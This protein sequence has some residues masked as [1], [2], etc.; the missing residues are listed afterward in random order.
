MHTMS[1][2]QRLRRDQQTGPVPT[3]APTDR[4]RQASC[5]GCKSTFKVFTEGSRGQSGSINHRSSDN[6]VS[7][8][9]IADTGAQSDLWSIE[10][11]LAC[12]LSCDDLRPVNLSLSAANR[13][14]I[15]IGGSILR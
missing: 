1:S 15:A 4:A 10:E 13:S 5:L 8:S 6:E 2:F 12:G 9:A 11:F 14:P 3:P 7:I